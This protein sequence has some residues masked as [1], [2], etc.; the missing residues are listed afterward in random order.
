MTKPSVV[1]FLSFS[2][3]FPLHGI[4][5]FSSLGAVPCDPVLSVHVD[6]FVRVGVKTRGAAVCVRAGDGVENMKHW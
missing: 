5:H 6:L 3:S 4:F 2:I 1:V